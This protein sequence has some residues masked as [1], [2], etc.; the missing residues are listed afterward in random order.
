LQREKLQAAAAVVKRRVLKIQH[1]AER[2]A[3]PVKMKKYMAKSEYAR[4]W[5]ENKMYKECDR[6]TTLTEGK[7]KS[8]VYKTMQKLPQDMHEFRKFRKNQCAQ[9]KSLEINP[10]VVFEMKNE[11]GEKLTVDAGRLADKSE[12]SVETTEKVHTFIFGTKE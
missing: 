8:I 5:R 4:K 11:K 9:G 10:E 12:F 1:K 6:R 7:L 2:E 3:D